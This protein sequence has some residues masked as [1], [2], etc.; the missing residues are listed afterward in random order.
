MPSPKSQASLPAAIAIPNFVRAREVAQTNACLYNLR[1]IEIAKQVGPQR[2]K[3]VPTG[4]PSKSWPRISKTGV[5]CVL[6]VAPIAS[7]PAMNA[8]LLDPKTHSQ[9]GGAAA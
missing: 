4:R 2:R 9:G 8:N 6:L 7:M 3:A 5:W 1:Q